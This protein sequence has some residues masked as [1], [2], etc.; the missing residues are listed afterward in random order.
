MEKQVSQ[1][2]MQHEW[3]I[4]IDFERKQYDEIIKIY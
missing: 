1:A 4:N 3:E 2:Q